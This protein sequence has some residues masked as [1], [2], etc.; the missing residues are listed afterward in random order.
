MKAASQSIGSAIRMYKV[1]SFTKGAAHAIV[2][3]IAPSRYNDARQWATVQCGSCLI[4][5]VS[6]T[7]RREVWSGVQ[8]AN[9]VSCL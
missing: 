4:S 8:I 9:G 6:T 5:K 7:S 3:G 1:G 2:F